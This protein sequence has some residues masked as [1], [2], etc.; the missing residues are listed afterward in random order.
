MRNGK[1]MKNALR[2]L[3]LAAMSAAGLAARGQGGGTPPRVEHITWQVADYIGD[4]DFAWD[5]FTCV[6]WF[7]SRY[8]SW[9]F[10][11]APA[12]FD[13]NTDVA[14]EL[15]AVLVEMVVVDDDLAEQDPNQQAQQD[16]EFFYRADA[17]GSDGPPPAPSL[18]GT[19]DRL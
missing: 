15:D 14:R 6:S 3:A 16:E 7:Y 5:E 1:N 9:D 10:W 17:Y 2:L 18:C 12:E 11:S 13:P 19:T 4:R 8:A